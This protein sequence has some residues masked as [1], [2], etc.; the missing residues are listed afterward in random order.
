MAVTSPSLGSG[1][2]GSRH[3]R[4]RCT[5]PGAWVAG[6]LGVGA[7]G[8]RA[9]VE[10]AGVV[11]VVRAHLAEPADAR[12]VELH[13]VDR[14]AGADA[15]QLGRAVAGE[16]DQRHRRLVRLGDGGVE[17]RRR[18][19]R[20]AGD[21]DR[22]AAR[23]APRPARRTR[24]SARRRRS[25]SRSPARARSA[26]ATGVERDPGQITAC[27]TPERASSSTSAEASAVLRLVGSIERRTL[28]EL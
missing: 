25:W 5:G 6:R 9:H 26:S 11:G 23:R 7:A 14:L 13:L 3:E 17:V 1:P 12:P 24:P 10:E 15:A 8:R 2:S 20:G 27:W 19:A 22:A 16:D 21:R 28:S 4:F 18:G